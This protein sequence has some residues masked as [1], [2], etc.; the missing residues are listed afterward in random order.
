M[1]LTHTA[2][3]KAKPREKQYK[4]SDSGGLYLLVK[5]SGYSSWKYD[6][7]LNNKRGTYTIGNYPDISLKQAREMHREARE[8]VAQSIH[9]KRIKEAALVKSS[10]DSERFSHYAYQWLAKQN[11]AESTHSDLKQRIE[12]NLIP[13]LDKKPVNEFT[14]ADILK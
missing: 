14:T 5:P 11:L 7:R 1:P 13:Y 10:L 6:Y 9:P 4:L 8:N 12:K 3:T 2:V